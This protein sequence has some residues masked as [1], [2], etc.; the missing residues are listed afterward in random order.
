[1]EFLKKRVTL[2]NVY[3]PSTGDNP[4]FFD[5]LSSKIDQFSNEHIII[6]G[7]WNVVLDTKL[8]ARNYK[9]TTNRPRS[10][11]KI[12]DLMMDYDLIDI[13]RHIFPSRR[14]YTWRQ[15]NSVKQGR[16]D[17]FLVSDSL[18]SEVA[19]TNIGVSYRSD[20][21]IVELSLK[22]DGMK[23][24]KQFWK[25]NNS[26]LTDRKFVDEVKSVILNLKKEY[27]LPVYNL[28]KN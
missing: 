10:R 26:L 19:G 14:N 1:M 2:V 27:A 25:F 22:K 4:N 5:A 7:D 23:R 17:Y 24:D 12:Q 3:G 8:D 21:S 28:E 16:L 13:F 9:Q 18:L 6:G 11:K 15:F 20:H